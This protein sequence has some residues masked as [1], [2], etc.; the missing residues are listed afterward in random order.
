MSTYHLLL[1]TR[2]TVVNK[3]N[4]TLCL[5]GVDSLSERHRL[6]TSAIYNLLE[7]NSALAKM[8]RYSIINSIQGRP[9]LKGDVWGKDLKKVRERDL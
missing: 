2:D 1:D 7:S 6:K 3:I 4:K 8:K 5:H 9:H